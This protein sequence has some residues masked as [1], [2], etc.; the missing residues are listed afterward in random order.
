MIVPLAWLLGLTWGVL[1]AMPLVS[2]GRRAAVVGRIERADPT[3]VPRG[4]ASNVRTR[5]RALV[6]RAG[7]L[8][9]NAS[10]PVAR[11]VTDARRRGRARV[12]DAQLGR[13][14][15]VA[16]DLLGVAVDAGCTPFLAV[17]TAAEWAPPGVADRLLEV[18]RTCRLGVRFDDALG[19][20]ARNTPR[21]RPLADALLTSER[22]GAPVGP[23]LARLASEERTALRRRAEAHARRVPVRLLFPLV[24]LVLP[25]F[26]LL[27]VV[28]GLAAGMSRL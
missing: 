15:P 20:A 7:A 8:V 23:A 12:A 27:T 26:V 16:L 17:Q 24:F 10:G 18:L 19:D 13:E 2:L 3:G 25:A 28:P 11:V 1:L 21:L 9:A 5:T 22:L 6:E 14:L 4:P